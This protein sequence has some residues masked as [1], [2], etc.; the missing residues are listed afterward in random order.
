MPGRRGRGADTPGQFLIDWAAGDTPSPPRVPLPKAIESP[1]AVP[2]LVQHLRWDFTGTFPAPTEAAIDAGILDDD[3]LS[4]QNIR[5]IHE[6][7]QRV[8]LGILRDLDAV[9]DARRRGIDPATGKPPRLPTSRQQLQQRL[10]SAQQRLERSFQTLRDT[11]EEAFGPE[12]ADAFE[13]AVRARHAGIPVVLKDTVPAQTTYAGRVS[14]GRAIARLPVPRPLS[15]AVRAAR[16]GRDESDQPIRP[17][18]DEVRAITENHAQKLIDLLLATPHSAPPGRDFMSEE[19]RAQL[20]AYAEDFGE[21]A[22]RQLEAYVQRQ[23][24]SQQPSSPR[25]GRHR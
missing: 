16:F 7:Q 12:A 22:T 4:P 18:P 24:E 20:A 6:E 19:Y 9:Q 23:A 25:S 13:K 3:D 10:E 5:A 11:Y 1:V 15:D 14:A 8:M 2:P 17:S 21:K